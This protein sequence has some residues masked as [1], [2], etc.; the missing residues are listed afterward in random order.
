MP[1][2]LPVGCGVQPWSPTAQQMAALQLVAAVNAPGMKIAA[3]AVLAPGDLDFSQLMTPAMFGA[4]W[5]VDR[6][7]VERFL[8]DP[9]LRG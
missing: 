6:G 4:I 3:I 5:T 7:S 8:N 1:P 9:A 2:P